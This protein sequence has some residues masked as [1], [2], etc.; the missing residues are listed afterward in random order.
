MAATAANVDLL[1]IESH[2]NPAMNPRGK[3]RKTRGSAIG[4]ITT[5][6]MATATGCDAK[7]ASNFHSFM[8]LSYITYYF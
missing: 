4:E 3:Q 8:Y 5:A 1:L 7:W 6:K 2:T